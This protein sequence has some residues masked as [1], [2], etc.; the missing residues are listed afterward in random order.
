MQVHLLHCKTGDMLSKRVRLNKLEMC[1][2]V[3]EELQKT[4]TVGS[5][6]R[7]IFTKAI[8]LTFPGYSTPRAPFRPSS[9]SKTAVQSESS[10]VEA[11]APD[12]S[13]LD[14][15]TFGNV[16]DGDLMN[17]LMDEASIFSLWETWNQL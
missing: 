7:A 8:Q 5:I 10:P 2:L 16:G 17:A 3:M 11:E 6:Y 12:Y 1:M 14:D 4:Y 9:V 13:Q 15:G